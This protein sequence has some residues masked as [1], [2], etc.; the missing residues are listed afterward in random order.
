MTFYWNQFLILS[1][2][3]QA[4][5]KKFPSKNQDNLFKIGKKMIEKSKKKESRLKKST[6][7]D[8]LGTLLTIEYSRFGRSGSDIR[9]VFRRSLAA[10]IH[11]WSIR[12]RIWRGNYLQFRNLESRCI[13]ISYEFCFVEI[14]CQARF[15]IK[16]ILLFCKF[17]KWWKKR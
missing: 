2:S 13:I 12:P 10:S 7:V 1:M 3:Y 4:D 15:K 17:K 8:W 16:F 9:V 11:D 6:R 5:T 14:N